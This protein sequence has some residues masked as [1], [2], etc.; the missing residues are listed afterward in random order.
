[1]NRTTNTADV[2][3]IST[4]LAV[5][6]PYVDAKR[7]EVYRDALR[8]YAE[9]Y[10]APWQ[11]PSGAFTNGRW[12]GR[13]MTVPYSIATGTQAMSFC[14]L[15]AITSE[16]KYMRVAER[17]VR[18]L[19][20]NWTEDG[21]QIFDHHTAELGREVLDVRERGAIGNFYYSHDGILWVWHWTQDEALKDTIRRVY[22][23]HIKGSRGLLASRDHGV[24]WPVVDVWSN[25]KMGA[26]P[27]VLIEYDRSMARDAEVREAVRRCA[28]FLCHPQFAHRIGVL[29]D[30]QMP[31]GEFAM[32]ATGFAG[33]TLAELIEPGVIFLQSDKTQLPNATDR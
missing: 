12:N 28:A 20:A 22:G 17:A 33:L 11:L 5:A 1:M 7:R 16:E 3:C 6:F 24:W 10:A 14:S 23:W 30:P 29:C 27:T 8:R 13:D 15:Y 19:L 2:G 25:S 9:D 18:Y 21:R 31:W 32:A 4:C 26:L